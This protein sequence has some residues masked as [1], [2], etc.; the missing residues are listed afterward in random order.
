[1]WVS[2]ENIEDRSEAP[3]IAGITEMVGTGQSVGG[4]ISSTVGATAE[5]GRV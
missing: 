3:T 2:Q 4:I 1:M 5:V